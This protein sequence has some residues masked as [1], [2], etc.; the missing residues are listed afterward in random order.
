MIRSNTDPYQ[1]QIIDPALLGTIS[2]ATDLY[3]LDT[4]CG[5]GYMA[6][7]SMRLAL[8]TSSASTPAAPSSTP[9]LTHRRRVANSFMPM[10]LTFRCQPTASTSSWSIVCRMVLPT[11]ASAT[12]SSPGYCA[13]V[14]A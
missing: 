6:R 7:N 5:E 9:R 11:L 2:D 10:S 4:G 1:T 13:L 3:V 14:A 8:Q 12:L